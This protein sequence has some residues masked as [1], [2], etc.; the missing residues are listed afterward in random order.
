MK[1][2]PGLD[3]SKIP[4]I[5][6]FFVGH[7]MHVVYIKAM[8]DQIEMAKMPAFDLTDAVDNVVKFSAAGI[9]AYVNGKTQ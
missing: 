4:L 5:I 3:E 1:A 8:L 9:R 2:C 7:L 6:V